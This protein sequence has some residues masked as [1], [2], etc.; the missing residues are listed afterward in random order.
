MPQNHWLRNESSVLWGTLRNLPFAALGALAI[1]LYHRHHRTTGRFRWMWL[2]M[3][4]SFLFYLPVAVLAGIWPL[5]G[6]LMIPKT[7]CYLLLV[8]T[9]FRAVTK[10][11]A[12]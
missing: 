1:L 4:L 11:P 3:L 12:R 2:Y 8:F 6:M 10:D 7:V 5:L 9:F